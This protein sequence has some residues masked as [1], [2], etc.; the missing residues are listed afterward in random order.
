[1]PRRGCC[2]PARQLGERN[3]DRVQRGRQPGRRAPTPGRSRPPGRSA[4]WRG[5][6]PPARQARRLVG[7]TDRLR[8]V[9]ASRHADSGPP[10]PIAVKAVMPAGYAGPSGE[11][12]IKGNESPEATGGGA[13]TLDAISGPRSCR[14]LRAEPTVAAAGR[15]STRLSTNS[16]R[17]SSSPSTSCRLLGMAGGHRPRQPPIANISTFGRAVVAA[18]RNSE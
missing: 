2:R 17:R 8:W 11:R 18:E 9:D 10:E 15:W 5:P 13:M 14:P 6:R 4:S 7:R 1:M 3:G 16:G 12:P